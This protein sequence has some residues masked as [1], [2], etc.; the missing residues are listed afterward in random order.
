MTS[1]S[2][3]QAKTAT[4]EGRQINANKYWRKQVNENNKEP[5]ERGLQMYIEIDGNQ[6]QTVEQNEY[7]GVFINRYGRRDKEIRNRITKGN[8]LDYH[9]NRTLIGIKKFSV[10]QK[11]ICAKQY[12]HLHFYT[13]RNYEQ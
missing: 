3:E 11:C 7:S 8:R 1:R 2:C 9:M 5:G 6:L 4:E 13:R 10:K 12:T